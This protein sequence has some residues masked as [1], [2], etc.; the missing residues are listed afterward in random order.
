MGNYWKWVLGLVGIGGAGLGAIV[1]SEALKDDEVVAFY[2]PPGITS[3][4]RSDP[5]FNDMD[6]TRFGGDGMI[7]PAGSGGVGP[8]PPGGDGDDSDADDVQDKADPELQKKEALY[9]A[10]GIDLDRDLADLSEFEAGW[11]DIPDPPGYD[12]MCGRLRD[13]SR[14]YTDDEY[15]QEIENFGMFSSRGAWIFHKLL[16]KAPNDG[17]RKQAWERLLPVVFRNNINE[18]GLEY[19][20]WL[21]ELL[22]RAD[23]GVRLGI[24]YSGEA[25]LSRD[26]VAVYW[27]RLKA[28]AREMYKRW[29]RD[30]VRHMAYSMESG[31][32][33]CDF[34]GD[35]GVD[36]RGIWDRAARKRISRLSA[37]DLIPEGEGGP[38]PAYDVIGFAYGDIQER[39]RK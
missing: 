35:E 37:L 25:H 32:Y 34:S 31:I 22:D 2:E 23:G 19:I 11:G 29:V 36:G 12:E 14:S 16:D 24:S 20:L 18:D 15:M 8:E 17:M 39:F 3:D 28:R 4:I 38:N 27:D 6:R 21:G 7:P 9:R 10:F 1:A 13:R 26:E 5:A 30:E 33:S